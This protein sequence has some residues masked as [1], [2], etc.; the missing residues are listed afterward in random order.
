MNTTTLRAFGVE[1]CKLADIATELKPHQRRVVE[2]MLR[3]DQPGLVVA[4]GLGSGKTFTSI[5]AQDALGMGSNVVVP[6]ALQENYAKEMRRHVVPGTGQEANMASLQAVS[7]GAE[8]PA[9]PL[10]I[11]DEAHRARETGT[12]T[13]QNLRNVL[14]GSEKRMLLTASP[15]YNRPSDIAPLVN[16]AAGENLLPADPTEFNKRYIQERRIAPSAW[17]RLVHGATYGVEEDVNPRTAGELR[18]V[19]SKW[20]DYHPSSVEGFP[21]VERRDVHVPMTPKQLEL[22]DAMMGKGPAWLRYKVKQGLPASKQES[23]DLNAFIGAVRQISNSTR[24]Y[25]AGAEQAPKIDTAVA[26][27]QR[28]LKDNPDAKAVVYSN[29]IDS[30]INPYKE[31]LQAAGIPFGEFTGELKKND[32]DQMVREYNE[33]KLKAL[34]LSSA[35]SEGLDLKGTRL[36]QILDPHWNNEK[37]RQVEGRGIRY[38]SH[39][40][41][42]EDQRK[43]LV[44]RY[45]AT[46]PQRTGLGALVLGKDSGGSADTYLSAMSDK[47]DQLINKMRALLPDSA[48]GG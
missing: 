10:T 25:S 41:L 12:S 33:G 38:G 30:G 44:E 28:M 23:K 3:A 22:Y 45:L 20:V 1:L 17:G 40:A 43:V 16:M 34:L 26:H 29:F 42:P 37:L 36:L 13:Y 9:N 27:F 35:G 47:K 2:K 6:A 18:K 8:L 15:F 46:R 11:V 48:N 31:R 24:A 7:R 4:H 19:F 5:A 39:A 14:Q 32:R 21:T